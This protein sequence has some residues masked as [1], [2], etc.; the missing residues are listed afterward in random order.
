MAAQDTTSIYTSQQYAISTITESSCELKFISNVFDGCKYHFSMT[1]TSADIFV[2]TT[3]R[4]YPMFPI[5]ERVALNDTTLPVG[6]GE[7]RNCPIYIPHGTKLVSNY[8]ALHH[9]ESHSIRPGPWEYM[10]FSGGPRPCVGQHKALAEASYTLVKIT[11]LFK[12][13]ESRHEKD[14]AR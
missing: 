4:I 7:K 2:N 11:Q 5:I 9:V 6:G 1:K 12:G 8:Y 13:Q 3:L 10:P 14:W